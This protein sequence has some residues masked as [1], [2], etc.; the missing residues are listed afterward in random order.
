M[1]ENTVHCLKMSGKIPLG[2]RKEFE[3]TFKFVSNQLSRHCIEFNLCSDTLM[4]NQYHFL[5]IWSTRESLD[6]FCCSNEFH[7][8]AGVYKTLGIL[9]HSET[10]EWTNIK[11][12][13]I[14][15]I[16]ENLIT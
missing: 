8:L 2:K 15:D 12:I 3:Q 6:D 1:K 7:L 4:P 11:P 13:G 10:L 14:P 5:S 16:R 9:E